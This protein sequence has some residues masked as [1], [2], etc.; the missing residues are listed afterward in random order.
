MK[1]VSMNRNSSAEGKQ[2]VKEKKAITKKKT[3]KKIRK[4][5]AKKKNESDEN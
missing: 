5:S 2:E 1:Y 4:N 3:K